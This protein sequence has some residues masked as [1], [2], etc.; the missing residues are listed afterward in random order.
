MMFVTLTDLSQ[1]PETRLLV[2]FDD[3]ESSFAVDSMVLRMER[4]DRLAPSTTF[5]QGV[6]TKLRKAERRT[7]ECAKVWVSTSLK[8][9]RQTRSGTSRD[10]L[11][12]SERRRVQRGALDTSFRSRHHTD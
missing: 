10:E 8:K 7:D 2:V 1:K 3:A 4:R 9:E 6:R 5:E 12:T 11:W